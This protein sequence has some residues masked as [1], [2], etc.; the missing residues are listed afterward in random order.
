MEEAPRR[1][2]PDSALDR[3]QGPAG[4]FMSRRLRALAAQSLGRCTHFAA[5]AVS[6]GVVWAAQSHFMHASCSNLRF[7]THA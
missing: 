1:R 4:I 7:H 2:L 5:S 6:A 3:P